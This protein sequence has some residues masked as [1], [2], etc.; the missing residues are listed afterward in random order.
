[1]RSPEPWLSLC[2]VR[3]MCRARLI[4]VSYLVL[5]CA[6]A[7]ARGES[8]AAGTRELCLISAPILNQRMIWSLPEAKLQDTCYWDTRREPRLSVPQAITIA[9]SFLN[10]RGEPDQL[11]LRSVELRRPTKTLPGESLYFYFV[12]FEDPGKRDLEKVYRNV[13]VLL[14]GSV[15]P[16]VVIKN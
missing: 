16:P 12:T 10:S 2:L 14:D 4:T 13:V 5:L 11:Q 1:M 8:K 15:I 6:V 7:P 3:P 9:R